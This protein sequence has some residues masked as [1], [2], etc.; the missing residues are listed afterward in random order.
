LTCTR[1]DERALI[2]LAQADP[3]S[4]AGREAAGLVLGIHRGLIV[5]LCGQMLLDGYELDDL[6]QEANIAGLEAI[7]YF[8]P[9][10]GFQFS[11][12]LADCVRR[13]VFRQ[14][15][16]VKQ[17]PLPQEGESVPGTDSALSAVPQI[18][19]SAGREDAAGTVEDLLEVLDPLAA[20]VVRLH[21]GVGDVAGLSFTQVGKRLGMT[22][23]AA[24]VLYEKAVARLRCEAVDMGLTA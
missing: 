23:K 14:R 24:T 12:Y 15:N 5:R 3:K 20:A 13:R 16:T 6:I 4:S 21:S 9:E 7:R 1:A 18:D 10:R 2:A 17:R 19:Q 11:T 8:R 22:W